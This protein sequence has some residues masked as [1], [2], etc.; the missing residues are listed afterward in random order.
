MAK[1]DVYNLVLSDDDK[2]ALLNI[3]NMTTFK[4]Q[5][6]EYVASIKERILNAP[7]LTGVNPAP[8]PA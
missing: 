6:V 7:L 1:G 2:T 8:N 4:G 5:D 3:I